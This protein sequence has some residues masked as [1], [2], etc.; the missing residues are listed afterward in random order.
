MFLVLVVLEAGAENAAF[1]R[2]VLQ[3]VDDILHSPWSPQVIHNRPALGVE[4]GKELKGR[5][6]RRKTIHRLAACSGI[7]FAG[8]MMSSYPDAYPIF[9]RI[10]IVLL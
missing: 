4:G 10:N 7:G 9:S 3:I 6:Y 5:L 8:I 1:V 2:V